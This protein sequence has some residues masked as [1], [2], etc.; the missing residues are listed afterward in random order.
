MNY[1][2]L[3]L[4]PKASKEDRQAY[5]ERCFV[6]G[7]ITRPSQNFLNDCYERLIFLE[8]DIESGKFVNKEDYEEERKRFIKTLRV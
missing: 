6:N 2:R 3:T 7:D 5:I 1:K 4:S 8:D